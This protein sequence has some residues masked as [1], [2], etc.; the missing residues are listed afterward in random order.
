[1]A[2]W[3]FENCCGVGRIQITLNCTLTE[4]LEPRCSFFGW[5][6][7]SPTYEDCWF[8]Y[9]WWKWSNLHIVLLCRHI[10]YNSF[11]WMHRRVM[12]VS[13]SATR[14]E[15]VCWSAMT[16][17]TF[18]VSPEQKIPLTNGGT[19]VL[20]DPVTCSTALSADRPRFRSGED[21][22]IYK[23]RITNSYIRTCTKVFFSL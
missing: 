18:I 23:S 14:M 3:M 20:L 11:G 6:L 22:E 4:E 17:D 9:F 19:K 2:S 7:W 1:M 5:I 8:E 16:I 21:D 15:L 10:T 13:A 12:A